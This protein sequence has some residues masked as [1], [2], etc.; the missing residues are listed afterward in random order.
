MKAVQCYELYGGIALKNH[1]FSFHFNVS[2]KFLY[3]DG[4]V[5]DK[6]TGKVSTRVNDWQ[7]NRWMSI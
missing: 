5:S 3:F 6:K 7:Y 1:A 4:K 2:S